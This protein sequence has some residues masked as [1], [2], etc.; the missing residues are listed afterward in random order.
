MAS[1]HVLV[2]EDETAA[3]QVLATAVREAGYFVDAAACAVEAAAMLARGDVDVALCDIQLPD[4]D[5][6]E[7]LK[8]SRSSGFD[9]TFVMVTAFASV[10]SAVEALRAGAEDYII[11]PV[12]HAEVLHRL[13]QIETMRGLREENSALRRVVHGNKPLYSCTSNEMCQVDRLIEKVAPTDRTVLVTGESGTGKNV[14]A[15]AIHDRS[16]RRDGPFFPVNCGAIPD[17]LLESELFGHT[18][19]AFTSADRSRKGLFL[20]ADRGTLFLDEISELPLHMQAKLL[21]VIED[22]QV[23]PL[24]SSHARHV[25]TRIIAATNRN[26][27]ALVGEGKFREDLYFRLSLFEIY[28]PPLRVRREDLCGLIQ[29]DLGIN[30][31]AHGGKRP[32]RLD[33]DAEAILLAY[34]WPGNVRELENVIA[35]ACILADGDRISLD[36]LPSELVSANVRPAQTKATT[37]ACDSLHDRRRTFEAEVLRNAIEEAGGDRKLAAARLKI[38]LSSLYAKLSEA[39]DP[40][41]VSTHSEHDGERHEMHK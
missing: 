11:K 9:T 35:R 20:E 13:S 16:A 1:L 41:E 23:R 12:R 10:E 33:P 32:W 28:I 34:H 26:L 17:Q 21:N 40:H 18:K 6:I 4:G 15:R 29:F 22:K 25:D 8:Q 36:E 30:E 7:L 37:G 14:V 38:S 39:G 3:R 24:G 31:R 19:G 5:G 2:I 27:R